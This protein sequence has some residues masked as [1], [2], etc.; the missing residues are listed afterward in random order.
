MTTTTGKTRRPNLDGLIAELTEQYNTPNAPEIDTLPAWYL[1]ESINMLHCTN[2][3]TLQ[4][5]DGTVLAKTLTWIQTTTTEQLRD[6]REYAL[7]RL[8]EVWADLLPALDTHRWELLAPELREH[9][10]DEGKPHTAKIGWLPKWPDT[11]LGRLNEAFSNLCL[12]VWAF[13]RKLGLP[14][15]SLEANAQAPEQTPLLTAPK[16]PARFRQ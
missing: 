6:R 12:A 16:N 9:P 11:D 15:W 7:T 8:H 5:N 2:A 13:N 1:G 3:A 14:A 10:D 4:L